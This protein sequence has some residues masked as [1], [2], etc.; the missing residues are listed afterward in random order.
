VRVVCRPL[1][2]AA[3]LGRF[4]GRLD[5]AG[6]AD[7]HLVLKLEDVFQETVEPVG[8]EMRAGRRV[9]QLRADA[10]AAAGLSHRAFEDIAHTQFTPDLLHVEYLPL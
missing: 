6:N 7:R 2:R 4:Q 8:P 1:G 10:H 3:G 5:D 9:D